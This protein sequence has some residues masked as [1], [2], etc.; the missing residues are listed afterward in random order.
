MLNS[1]DENLT[2]VNSFQAHTNGINRIR[3][4]PFNAKYVA[5]ASSDDTVIIW[6]SNNNWLLVRNYTG[7][8]N[9][10]SGIEY[11]N[12]DMVATG[13]YTIHIWYI[14]TGITSR[15]IIT[16]GYVYT[17]QL[18]CNGIHLAA[19]L[20]TNNIEIYNINTGS[21][22]T[23]LRGHIGIVSNLALISY[24]LLASTSDDHTV[25]IWDLIT[26]TI[27]FNLSG[28][29]D[30]VRGLKLVSSDILA[31]G[32]IDKTVRLWNLTNGSLIRT[33]MHSERM[34][35]SV[36]MLNSEILVSGLADSSINLWNV[37]TG[38]LQ[39][40]SPLVYALEF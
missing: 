29:T 36:V 10:V 9:D 2:L 22:V 14:S 38:V 7:H 21:L 17:L 18:M 40:K 35:F 33:L 31:T 39:K 8:T 32:S 25:R 16:C 5:T 27:K 26:N 1:Y 6:D 23:I 3:Q 20:T 37:N 34:S 11:I 30:I 4:S 15:I 13:A 28:H 24:D 19:G 12:E